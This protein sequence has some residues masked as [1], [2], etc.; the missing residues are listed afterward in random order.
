MYDELREFEQAILLVDLPDDGLRAGDIGTVVDIHAGGRGCILEFMTLTGRT[1]AVVPLETE[2]VR[3]VTDAD[4]P[5]A[6]LIAHPGVA[7][8][9]VNGADR[10]LTDEQ[11]A[12]TVERRMG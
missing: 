2:H 11:T 9:P 5:S 1:V 10:G 7:E 6:R 4:I 3:T 8:Q 12:A